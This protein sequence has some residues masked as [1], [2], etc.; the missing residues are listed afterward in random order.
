[1]LF[2]I[3][4]FAVSMRSFSR[5][6]SEAEHMQHPDESDDEPTGGAGEKRPEKPRL[7]P[8]D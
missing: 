4:S 1:M 7:R 6:R 2:Y 5:L 3:I 8:V